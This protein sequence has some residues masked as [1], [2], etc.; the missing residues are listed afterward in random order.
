MACNNNGG[1]GNPQQ[2]DITIAAGSDFTAYWPQWTHY[3]GPVTVLVGSSIF[4]NLCLHALHSSDTW[5]LALGLLALASA[6]LALS[7]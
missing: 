6:T 1:T 7:G 2:T 3:E 4:V 5:Q